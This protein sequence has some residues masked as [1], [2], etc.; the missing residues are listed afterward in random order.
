MCDIRN[1]G[2]FVSKKRF[3]VLLTNYPSRLGKWIMTISPMAPYRRNLLMID[4]KFLGFPFKI[5][6][7]EQ[8]VEVKPKTGFAKII[9]T[10]DQN[11][12]K[13]CCL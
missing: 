1:E 4:F 5:A 7:D 6:D 9:I 3:I 8:S 11:E 2:A 10:W 13:I 12:S